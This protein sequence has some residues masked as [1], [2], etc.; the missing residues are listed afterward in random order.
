M[1]WK[2]NF[3]WHFQKMK[4]SEKTHFFIIIELIPDVHEK[5]PY[6][7]IAI[8]EI[9]LEITFHIAKYLAEGL[10]I[11]MTTPPESKPSAVNTVVT[12]P[13]NILVFDGDN[14]KL[15]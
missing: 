9:V 10:N 7:I 15:T 4:L 12:V 13:V 6:A 8:T 1:N 2:K 3:R 11:V 5:N 14:K